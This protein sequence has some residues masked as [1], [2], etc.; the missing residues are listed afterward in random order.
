[1]H[2]INAGFPFDFFYVGLHLKAQGGTG[3]LL[4]SVSYYPYCKPEVL[5]KTGWMTFVNEEVDGPHIMLCEME[6]GVQVA[7][8]LAKFQHK[9]CAVAVIIN[10]EDSYQLN[11]EQLHEITVPFIVVPAS[12]GK[13]L[14]EILNNNEVGD[15]L[16]K[17]EI[18]SEVDSSVNVQLLQ[19]RVERHP[20]EL[21]SQA[22]SHNGRSKNVSGMCKISPIHT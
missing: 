18:E 19:S 12:K 4:H 16:A 11:P 10:C 22:E 14:N 21:D 6:K 3:K 20:T 17:I 8:A 1:L 9:S 7:D 13:K 15:I 2:G 5:F